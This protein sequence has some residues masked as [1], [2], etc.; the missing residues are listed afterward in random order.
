A[1]FHLD[2]APRRYPG[3]YHGT[4]RGRV[5]F[6]RGA[7]RLLRVPGPRHP[8]RDA[9]RLRR[10]RHPR[11]ARP[12]PRAEVARARLGVPDGLRPEGLGALRI[13]GHRRGG[14]APRRLRPPAAARP[15]PRGRPL[16]RLGA[17][18][19]HRP[20]GVRHGRGL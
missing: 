8:G 20:G 18:R 15:P 12:A 16:G 3:P 6:R 17:D 13:R 9:R 11:R 14:V 1:G 19:D 10:A 4:P 7:A 2:R 5:W